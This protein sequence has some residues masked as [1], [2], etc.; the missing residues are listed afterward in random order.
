MLVD[1]GSANDCELAVRDRGLGGVSRRVMTPPPMLSAFR[2][3]VVGIVENIA[4]ARDRGLPRRHRGSVPPIPRVLDSRLRRGA[5]DWGR[6]DYSEISRRADLLHRGAC[7][8][9]RE[10]QL[11]RRLDQTAG[12]SEAA[13]LTIVRRVRFGRLDTVCL[14]GCGNTPTRRQAVQ[15][16]GRNRFGHARRLRRCVWQVPARGY[17]RGS[18]RCRPVTKGRLDAG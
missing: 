10:P 18:G 3:R 2:V 9:P 14:L 6:D 15:F 13:P 16:F 7:E 12:S 4:R 11:P 5:H 1:V 8:H 17:R